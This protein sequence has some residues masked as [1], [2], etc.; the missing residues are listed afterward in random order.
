MTII[1]GFSTSL[2]LFNPVEIIDVPE[3]HELRTTRKNNYLAQIDPSIENQ[4][5]Y[6]T[7]YEKK[8]E[9]NKEVYL[10][11]IN[12][13]N[14]N[15]CGFVRVT[16]FLDNY[17]LGWESLIIKEGTPAPIG[18]EI[19]FSIY[20]LAFDHLK[21]SILGPW[22]VT[23][24]NIHMMKIHDHMGFVS[25]VDRINGASVLIVTRSMYED[26]KGKFLKWGFA[27]EFQEN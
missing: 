6:F 21:R 11:I 7:E 25:Q 18:I 3:I 22:I 27:N 14:N 2:L 8:K 1:N 23:D 24:I 17:S 9:L 16:N 5:K 13:K 15:A 26:K 20:Y 12:K 19:C 10:K 4:Y